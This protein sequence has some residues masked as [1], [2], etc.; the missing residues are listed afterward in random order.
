MAIV[1]VP[2]ILLIACANFWNNSRFSSLSI[3]GAIWSLPSLI[4]C[5]AV[6][7]NPTDCRMALSLFNDGKSVNCNVS[8]MLY[9]LAV[10]IPATRPSSFNT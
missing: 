5:F 2:G 4:T 3:R 10:C 9:S 6:L 7:R 1:P 8:P